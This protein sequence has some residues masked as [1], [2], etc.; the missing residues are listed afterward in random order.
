[1]SCGRRAAGKR[2]WLILPALLPR[3]YPSWRA[4]GVP[5]PLPPLRYREVF[6]ISLVVFSLPSFFR[7]SYACFSFPRA[8]SL[9]A[10]LLLG[11]RSLIFF[12]LLWC[13]LAICS[14]HANELS[15]L[16][17]SEEE[18]KDR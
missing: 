2:R 13:L 10:V 9:F 7:D 4:F 11:A 18:K 17:F 8:F 3:V 1:M 5:T 15:R 12:P 14:Q 16:Y 6:A